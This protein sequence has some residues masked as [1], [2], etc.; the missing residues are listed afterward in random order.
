MPECYVKQR[1]YQLECEKP[2]YRG[3]GDQNGIFS[4]TYL[5]ND[6]Q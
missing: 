6:R 1:E 4:V 5:L 2:L 3:L